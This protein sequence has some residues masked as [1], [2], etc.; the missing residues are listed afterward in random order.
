MRTLHLVV[1]S[2]ALAADANA[3]RANVVAHM[4]NPASPAAGIADPNVLKKARDSAI[5]LAQ[6]GP[7]TASPELYTGNPAEAPF[8]WM[9]LLI[10]PMPTAQNP[11]AYDYCTGQFITPKVVLTAGHCLKDLQNHPTG[12]WYDLTKASFVLQYQNGGGSQTFKIV[13]GETDPLWVYPSNYSSMTAD[14][15]LAARF[16]VW[17]HD[18]AMVLVDGT[19]PTGAMPYALDWKGKYNYASRIGYPENILGS[20]IIQV[21]PGYVFFA[22]AIQLGVYSPPNVVVQWGPVTDATQ[23]MSGGAWVANLSATEGPNNN[24]LIAMTSAL[25]VTDYNA[26]LFPGGAFAAYLTAAEFNPLLTSVSNGC[27]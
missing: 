7:S 5:R 21:V 13:C 10:N 12:P 8:K 20:E 27:K 14:Q 22:D 25:P 18:I 23:G 17:A 6:V 2:I 1:A 16:P 4:P 15:Q 19:S 3:I 26:P 9:G 24:V 11:D